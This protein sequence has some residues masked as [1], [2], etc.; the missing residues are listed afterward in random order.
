MTMIL[1]YSTR[2]WRSI[3]LTYGCG[4]LQ[5]LH[6]TTVS[7][8]CSYALSG[9]LRQLEMRRVCPVFNGFDIYQNVLMFKKELTQGSY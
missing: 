4:L 6:P 9:V 7:V 5:I 1:K 3:I 2:I 8:I